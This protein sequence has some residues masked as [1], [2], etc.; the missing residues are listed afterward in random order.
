MADLID[1]WALLNGD[2]V[3]RVTEYDEAGFSMRYKAV[4]VEAIRQ[5]PAVDAVEVC[6]CEYC[7]WGGKCEV[8]SILREVDKIPDPYCAAGKRR[9]DDEQR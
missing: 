5:A 8:E 2:D 6:R 7:E 4:P 1:R 3:C 9:T